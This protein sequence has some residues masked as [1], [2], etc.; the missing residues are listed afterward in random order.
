MKPS[1]DKRLEMFEMIVTSREFDDQLMAI[2][3]AD[4]TP[5]FDMAGGKVPGEIHT[6]HG[7]EACAAGTIMQLTADDYITCSHRPHHHAI[8]RGVDINGMAAEIFGKSTGLNGGK[9]GHM[10]IYSPK[11]NFSS[12][13]IIAEGMGP[14]AGMAMAAK[15]QG[16]EGVGVSFMGEAAVNQ[17][18]FHEVMN[19]AGLYNLPYICVVEDNNWGVSVCKS[20]STAIERNSDRASSYG[21]YGEYVETNDPDDIYEAMGRCL[22]RARSGKGPSILELKTYRLFGHMLGDPMPYMPKDEKDA[23][24]DCTVDYREK[25][26]AEGVMTES[27]ADAIRERAKERAAAAMKFADESAYPDPS[28]AYNNQYAS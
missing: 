27:E 19:M 16:K 9:G 3:F 8:A 24:K 2:Y 26:I 12:S 21:A 25:L 1:K 20:A 15:I 28:E 6:S 14:A 18:A 7:H 11:H 22:E 23:F 17:G 4:K 13:G 5:V 10:H